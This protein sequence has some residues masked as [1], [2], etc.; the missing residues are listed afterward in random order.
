VRL[1]VEAEH[2]LLDLALQPVHLELLR[3]ARVLLLA[4]QQAEHRPVVVVQPLVQQECVDQV[5]ARGVL[6]LHHV[7]V[8]DALHEPVP[9]LLVAVLQNSA[10]AG[11]VRAQQLL[12]L[13]QQA[14]QLVLT[15]PLP[16]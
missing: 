7:D 14:L 3:V 16:L 5:D 6:E 13:D 15:S 4:L 2:L 10:L 12:V 11:E 9:V 8:D 1:A